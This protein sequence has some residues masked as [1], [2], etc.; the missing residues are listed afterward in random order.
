MADPTLWALAPHSRAKHEILRKYL[1][2]WLPIL[3]MT[4]PAVYLIDGF[5]GPGRYTGNEEGS[6]LIMIR[7]LLS[8]SAR[9]KI[10][11]QVRFFFIEERHDRVIHLIGE[12]KK[13]ASHRP[14]NVKWAVIEGDYSERMNTLLAEI[15]P[16]KKLPPTFLFID[17]FGYSETR[18]ALTTT[19]LAQPRCE[20]LIYVPFPFIVRFLDQASVSPAFT[21]LY[22]DER[23]REA[24]PLVGHA[25]TEKLHDLY[26]DVLSESARF[27]RSFEV[28]TA[29]GQGYH[30]FFA[31]NHP[32][33]LEKMKEAMWKVDPG[34]G[35]RFRDSTRRD[36]MVLFEP[37]PDPGMLEKLLRAQFGGRAVDISAVERYV[38]L[39]TPFLRSH[40]RRLALRPGEAKGWI[41]AARPAGKTRD[42]PVGTK[43]RFE[44]ST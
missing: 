6:P 2:A 17:P 14:P 38:V 8:H 4:Q 34:A 28:A 25:R 44:R 33:G 20:V 29:E 39:E 10:T 3:G 18:L 27:V 15:P 1:D 37:E 7:A 26:L 12:L 30:L 31:S 23:W 42:Y 35:S 5:A 32:L 40:L 19:I 24:L 11:A 13:L 22:G 21:N 16:G 43:L 36:Q 41:K 9:D